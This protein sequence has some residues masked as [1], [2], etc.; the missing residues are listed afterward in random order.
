MFLRQIKHNYHKVMQM[1][2]QPVEH[3]EIVE[4][5]ELSDSDRKDKGFGSTGK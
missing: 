2:V 4:S 1:L 5:E 3:M